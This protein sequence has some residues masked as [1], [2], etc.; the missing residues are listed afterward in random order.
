MRSMP[1]SRVIKTDEELRKE[2]E[3]DMTITSDEIDATFAERRDQQEKAQE[4]YD[5]K[6][7]APFVAALNRK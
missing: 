7:S 2:M 5:K 3:A 1:V 4:T 6:T